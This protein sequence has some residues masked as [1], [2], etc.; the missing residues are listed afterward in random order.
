M[1][2]NTEDRI[3]RDK[4]PKSASCTSN[5]NWD[6]IWRLQPFDGTLSQFREFGGGKMIP[7]QIEAGNFFGTADY[8]PFYKVHVEQFDWIDIPV[9]D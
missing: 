7:T 6:K 4:P 2:L 3:P 8:F 9:I 5:A 1:L